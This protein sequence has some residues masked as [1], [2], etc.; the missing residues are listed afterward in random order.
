[1]LWFAA[2]Y[3]QLLTQT[4]AM[5]ARLPETGLNPDSLVMMPLDELVSTLAFLKRYKADNES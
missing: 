3:Q 2:Y 1:M 5:A 4:Q